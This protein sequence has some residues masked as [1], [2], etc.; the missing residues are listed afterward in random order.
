M[1]ENV[2]LLVILEHQ[3]KHTKIIEIL[4]IIEPRL[5]DLSVEVAGGVS[6]YIYADVGTYPTQPVIYMGDG[7]NHLP[8][9]PASYICR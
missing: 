1:E 5:K 3:G 9:N 6:T 4:K 2:K 7:I 8:Y